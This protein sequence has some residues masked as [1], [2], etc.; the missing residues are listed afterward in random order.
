MIA[1]ASA[2]VKQTYSTAA[3]TMPTVA[4]VYSTFE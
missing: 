3:I 2:R 1:Q 4:I